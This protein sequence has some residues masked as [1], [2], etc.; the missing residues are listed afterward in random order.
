MV[1]PRPEFPSLF[2][3]RSLV[4]L[5][6]ADRSCHRQNSQ[7]PPLLGSIRTIPGES[8]T[9]FCPLQSLDTVNIVVA[10]AVWEQGPVIREWLA[11]GQSL[12]HTFVFV[13]VFVFV[14]VFVIV[15]V[16]ADV[17]LYPMMYNMLGPTWFWDDLK[18]L[19]WKCWSDDVQTY[20]QTYRISSYRL[21][22]SGRRG[23]VKM[24]TKGLKTITKCL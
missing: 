21:D 7:C 15:I 20:R 18:A 11:G 22:P 17:I 3:G 8:I 9:S 2:R 5:G 10:A 19:D 16:I 1:S 6:S 12:L 23:R 4:R 24:S 13:F 14:C